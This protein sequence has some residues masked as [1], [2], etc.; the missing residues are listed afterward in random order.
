[1]HRYSSLMRIFDPRIRT[2]RTIALIG[3]A[4]GAL[5]LALG[6]ELVDGFWAGI[7]AG[8]AWAIARELH[9]DNNLA[10]MAAGAIGGV[11]EALVGGVGLGVCW[12]L[13]VFVRI[14]VRTTGAAPKT[15]DLVVNLIVVLV[16]ST[17]LPGFLAGLGVAVAL[18][19]SPILPNPA[20]KTHRTWAVAYVAAALTGLVLSPALASPAS[21]GATW[22]L[23]SLSMIA[24][25]GLFSSTRPK[26]VGDID[27][28]PLDGARLRLGRIELIALLVVVTVTT[29]GAGVVPAAPAFAAVFA[30]GAF[31]IRE[32]VAS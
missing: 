23:F 3:I 2:H 24:S 20:P 17:T 6:G 28:V 32:L 26:S 7:A 11:F 29:L 13:I 22:L 4:S 14:I 8:L 15:P 10:G 5:A 21:S 27:G 30:T 18:F 19:L 16:V 31:S 12:L 1:M 9:P 25:V